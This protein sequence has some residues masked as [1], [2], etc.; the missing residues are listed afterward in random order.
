MAE[1]IQNMNGHLAAQDTNIQA[2][3]KMHAKIAILQEEV[4]ALHAESQTCD[5]QL[6]NANVMLTAQGN[7]TTMLMDAYESIHQCVVPNQTIPHFNNATFFPPASQ[8][9]PYS[10]G[11]SARQAQVME[12]LYFNLTPVLSTIASNS[13]SNIAGPS[14]SQIN[15]PS[16]ES[17]SGSGPA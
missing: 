4:K 1:L 5:S 16:S 9:A 13:M 17:A 6:R 15:C 7:H 8:S 11:M 12:Q 3:E 10:H 2:M 14:G